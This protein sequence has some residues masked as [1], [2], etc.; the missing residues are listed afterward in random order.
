MYI[1]KMGAAC[2]LIVL[3]LSGCAG[4]GPPAPEP[5]GEDG[6]SVTALFQTES[7]EP[8]Q[9]GAAQFS[10]G[11]SSGSCPLDG[12][13]AINVSGLPR[14]GDLLLTLF[15]RRQEVR[16]AMTLSFTEGA[17]IDATTGEDGVGHITVRSDTDEVVL[18]FILEEGG[19]LR[20]TLWLATDLR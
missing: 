16:G 10:A 7:G 11:E 4:S 19:A 12:G 14:S 5:A 9:G 20:C 8:L 17:V 6:L 15:D 18:L 13:G 2:L 1:R 3:F